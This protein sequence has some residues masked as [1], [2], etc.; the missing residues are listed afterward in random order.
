MGKSAEEL[1]AEAARQ[2]A[3]LGDTAD[4]IGDRVSPGRIVERRT[5]RM[6]GG[7]GRARETLMGRADHVRGGAHEL[8]GTASGT[9]SSTAAS[10]SE[11]PHT[12]AESATHQ[13]QGNPLAAGLVAFGAGLLAAAAFPG[14]KTEARAAGALKEAAH[15]LAEQAKQVG[16]E[17]AQHLQEPAQEAVAH[18]KEAATE[19]A[20]AVQETA[21][22]KAQ[23]TTQAGQQAAGEVKG[24]AQGAKDHVQSETKQS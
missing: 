18:V 23:E 16:Q 24:T 17:A 22:A 11:L 9:A 12:M 6:K 15:P 13:A 4:A 19:G 3:Q 5:N 2:R 20:G 1:R 7:L 10:A 14:T 8:A 21:Q